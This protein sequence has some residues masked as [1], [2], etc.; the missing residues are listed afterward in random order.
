MN[1]Q[2]IEQIAGLHFA[3]LYFYRLFHQSPDQTWVD[4]LKKDEFIE[5]WPL[6]LTPELEESI[7][8]MRRSLDTDMTELSQDYADLFVGPNSLLAPPW[9]SVYLT[10]EQLNCGLPTHQVKAFYQ[11]YGLMIDTGE[12]EPEDHIG[13]MFAFLAYITRQ[14]LEAVGN[15]ENIDPWI[16][17][18]KHFLEG[19][20][21]TWV[22]RFLELM[23]E[24]AQTN[25]Y[26]SG[27][28]LCRVTL[29]QFVQFSKAT[30]KPTR[31]FR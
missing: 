12:Q 21:M 1:D 28:Q 14:G 11:Q 27:S 16:S 30:Y 29:D 20:V 18:C 31:L 2:Q 9:A 5:H 7:R 10:A 25:F 4:N 17:A 8:C 26:R 6:Q 15:K 24:H 13:L 3:S 19:H 22:P 23:G